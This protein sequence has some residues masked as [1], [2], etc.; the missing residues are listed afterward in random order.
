MIIVSEK[1]FT[2]SP[3]YKQYTHTVER[4]YTKV[5]II[6]NNKDM[7]CTGEIRFT[8]CPMTNRTHLY[9]NWIIQNTPKVKKIDKFKN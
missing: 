5:T 7:K 8:I 4:T 2:T 9:H 3:L 1:R 6:I